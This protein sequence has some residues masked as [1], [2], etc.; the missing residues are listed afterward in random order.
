MRITGHR[1]RL[2]DLPGDRG[3]LGEIPY[4]LGRFATLELSSDAGLVGVSYC[5]YV[6]PSTAAA[7][8]ATLDAVATACHG[9]DPWDA[10][11]LDRLHGGLSNAAGGGLVTR[12]FS[13]L[14]V[15]CWDLRAREVELP[16]WRLLG[17][18]EGR[19]AC[20]ASG[21]LW[22]HYDLAEL[23]R[24]SGE[25][26]DQGFRAMKLRCGAEA[27]AAAE[28]DRLRVCRATVG[29]EIDLMI[30]INQGWSVGDA[31]RIG[32]RFAE[33]DLFWLE[34][35]THR[36]DFDGHARIA[37]ALDT[38]ICA[39]EYLYGLAPLKELCARRS[40]DILM[41]DCLRAG[42]IT[43]FMKAAHLAEGFNL[44]IVSHLTTEFLA[45]AVAACANGLT[46]EHMP[47]TF[48][49]WEEPPAIDADGR[50]VLAAS[51]GFGLSFDQAAL[52]RF[53]V[54]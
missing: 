21:H 14:D 50:L 26:A 45:P 5:G 35:P 11:G 31:V 40:V 30:D 23:E 1:I 32:R 9:L 37:A 19:V 8:A 46:V 18:S 44:P 53:E 33:H 36:D 47:W 27:T 17:A 16:L 20:Y 43:G 15:A 2:V 7:L 28:A 25:L 48:P 29:D 49:L 51:P 38:P 42:G 34:D 12:C 52:D 54:R 10:Q 3:P 4:R 22:R 24:W 39:G 41:A 6:S 13:A